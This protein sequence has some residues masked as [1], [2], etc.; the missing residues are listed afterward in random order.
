MARN[1]RK[2]VFRIVCRPGSAIRPQFDFSFDK[3]EMRKM[4]TRVLVILI[5]AWS[6]LSGC[7]NSQADSDSTLHEPES[8]H[9]VHGEVGALYGHT[10]R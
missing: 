1:G 5:A 3:I 7:A 4:V 10:A 9:E 8:N 6:L 2:Q